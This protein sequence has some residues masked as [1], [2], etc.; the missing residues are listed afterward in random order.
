MS[1][2]QLFTIDN[3][4]DTDRPLLAVLADPNSIFI[5]GLAL[6]KHRSLYANVTNDKTVCYYTAGITQT[7]PFVALDKINCNYIK[8]YEP[9]ILDGENPVSIKEPEAVPAFTKRATGTMRTVFTRVP[10]TIFLILFVPI[11]STLF[12]INSAIQHV[13]SRQRIRLHET[14]R[15]GIDIGNYRIPLINDMRQELEDMF[16]NMNNQ[17]DQEYLP[18]GSEELASPTQS[19]RLN[20]HASSHLSV[21]SLDSEP[22]AIEEL[23]TE[24]IPEMPEMPTLALT[25]AQFAMIEALD[26]VGFKKFPVYIHKHRHSH[27]AIIYRRHGP[28][29]EEGWVVVNHWLS[30]FEL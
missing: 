22:D 26:N 12:L 1:G 21:K 29:F 4:R 10:L 8:G 11:G 5:K 6:F 19:P 3:F 18:A 23:K 14:G 20:R 16:E 28:K 9:V 27:A 24:Q 17:Q 7:D 2:R 25:T 30:T 13:R 15:A